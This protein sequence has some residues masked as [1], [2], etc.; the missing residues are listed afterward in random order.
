MFHGVL[1]SDAMFHILSLYLDTCKCHNAAKQIST[2]F[3]TFTVAT[4][5]L[6]FKCQV[7]QNS[8]CLALFEFR[9]VLEMSMNF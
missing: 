4:F 6:A 5:N 1:I 7:A 9:L 8:F 3:K 2:I